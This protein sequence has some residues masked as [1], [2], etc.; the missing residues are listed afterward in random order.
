MDQTQVTQLQYIG[1]EVIRD[2]RRARCR[3]ILLGVGLAVLVIE[4]GIAWAN[5]NRPSGNQYSMPAWADLLVTGS[6]IVATA[7]IVSAMVLLFER[8]IASISAA[9]VLTLGGFFLAAA[10]LKAVGLQGIVAVK[11]FEPPDVMAWRDFFMLLSQC[12][13]SVLL[14]AIVA[15]ILRCDREQLLLLAAALGLGLASAA[16]D[17]IYFLRFYWHWRFVVLWNDW[18]RLVSNG[19]LL[20]VGLVLVATLARGFNERRAQRRRVL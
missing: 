14:I 17:G 3:A 2:I 10:I 12:W 9:A 11:G 13:L 7:G 15:L 20:L 16:M 4:L 19:L 5:V 1:P 8:R 18:P 6:M